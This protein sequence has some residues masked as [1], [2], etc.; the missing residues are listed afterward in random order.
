MY[1]TERDSA[2][3]KIV[4]ILILGILGAGGVIALYLLNPGMQ[5]LEATVLLVAVTFAA[6]GSKGTIVGG[7]I[8]S[9]TLYLASALAAVAYPFGASYTSA[10]LQISKITTASSVPVTRTGSVLSFLLLTAIIW[11][12][13]EALARVFFSDTS[14]PALGFLDNVGGVLLYAL[15][16]IV[17]AT[18]LFNAL[19]YTPGMKYAHNHALFRPQFNQVMSMLY[20]AQSFW[21]GGRPPAIY[22]Y[23][24]HL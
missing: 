16:G 1:I 5:G 21:F 7:V 20:Q 4:P 15:I 24:L 13:L 17:V 3:N 18:L 22:A 6:L 10:F 8:S 2:T 19:G 11:G 12:I 23:D 9:I 14:I